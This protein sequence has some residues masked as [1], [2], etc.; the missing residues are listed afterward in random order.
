MPP[1]ER[2][3]VACQTSLTT[4]PTDLAI[5]LAL[6]SQA[7]ISGWG[8]PHLPSGFTVAR[9]RNNGLSVLQLRRA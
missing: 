2:C 3:F 6:S 1:G 8:T 9:H 7:S 4:M 5:P